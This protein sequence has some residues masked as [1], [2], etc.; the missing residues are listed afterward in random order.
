MSLV[1]EMNVLRGSCH[2]G[3]IR[4]EFST[5]QTPANL[6]PRA[7]DCTFCR[8][9]GAAYIS[10]PAGRLSIFASESPALARYR[11]GSNSAQFVLCNLCGVLVAVVYEHHGVLHGAVNAPCLDGDAGLGA[12][13]PAS[14][15][16]LSPEARISRWLQLWIPDVRLLIQSANSRA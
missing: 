2:C 4:L 11:Q 5:H 10:D 13:I 6:V 14:P 15:Q 7:C 12:P 8:K 3:Q 1:K 16:E 9:H